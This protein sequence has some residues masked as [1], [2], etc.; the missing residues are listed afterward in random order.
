MIF[1]HAFLLLLAALALA[2]CTVIRV[3]MG[4]RPDRMTLTL[5]PGESTFDDVLDLMG[6][7]DGFCREDVTDEM[8]YQGYFTRDHSAIFGAV[9]EVSDEPCL[10]WTTF[11]LQNSYINPGKLIGLVTLVMGVRGSAPLLFGTHQEKMGFVR[12]RFDSSGVVRD[13]HYAVGP[14]VLPIEVNPF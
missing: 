11:Q 4:H 8:L 9:P 6:P 1:R 13:L 7:P 5:Q 10:L 12:I 3:D 2:G 14:Q